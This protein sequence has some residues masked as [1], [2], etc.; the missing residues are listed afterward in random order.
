MS[1]QVFELQ[2]RD[3]QKAAKNAALI[4]RKKNHAQTSFYCSLYASRE[5]GLCHQTM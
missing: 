1:V 4:E 2:N 5:S 3:E